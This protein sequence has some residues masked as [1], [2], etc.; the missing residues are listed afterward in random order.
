MYVRQVEDQELNFCVSGKLWN[1]S[2][3]MLDEET[4]SQWSHLLGKC[5]KGKLKDTELKPIPSVIADWGSWKEQNPN[6]D[7]M[8]WPV[9]GRKLNYD[10][11]FYDDMPEHFV[12]GFVS[13]RTAKSY[14]FPKLYEKPLVNDEVA[15][16]SIVIW[17]D[18]N[19]R[20]AWCFDREIDDRLLEFE[21]KDD[22][23][24]DLQTDSSW[25]LRNG[26]ATSGELQGTKLNPRVV[27]PSYAQ[28]W[29]M[30]HP[31]SVHWTD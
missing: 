20:A 3:I 5:M 2:L 4:Q 15:G 28:A 27:I 1:R 14:S 25:D 21:L 10:V 31:N 26:V 30:F 23:I 22:S 8:V 12:I 16:Q 18:K 19:S 24:V 7:A 17:F 11:S 13:R 9:Q 6:T 29:K